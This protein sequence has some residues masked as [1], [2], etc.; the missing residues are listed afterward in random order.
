[1]RHFA[2]VKSKRKRYCEAA[3]MTTENGQATATLCGLPATCHFFDDTR[4]PHVSAFLCAL[5][6]DALERIIAVQGGANAAA[7][8]DPQPEPDGSTKV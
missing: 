6:R 1:M 5:C 3:R 8:P 4:T 2:P 7:K